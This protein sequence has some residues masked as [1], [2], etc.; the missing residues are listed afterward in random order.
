[1]FSRDGTTVLTASTDDTVRLWRASTAQTSGTPLVAHEATVWG[2]AFS[3]DGKTVLTGSGDNTARF[4]DAATGKLTMAPIAH[5][6]GVCGVAFSP[7]GKTILTG[8][9]DGMARLWDASSGRPI[10]SPLR[11]HGWVHAVAFSPDGKVL[12]T[13]S[14]DRMAMLW[15]AATGTPIGR[16]MQHED[17]IWS[18]AF[19]PDGKSVLTGSWDATARI[20]DAATGTPIGTPIEPSGGFVW[21]VAFSPDGKTILT[22]G[23]DG[24][25]RIWDAATRESVGDPMGHGTSVTAVAF[26][27]DGKTV[28]TGSYD[29]TVRLWDVA[30]RR[31]IGRPMPH[32]GL[33][34]AVAFSP[35]GKTILTGSADHLARLWPVAELPDDLGRVATWVE[36]ITAL[37][38]DD[39]G[40]IKPLDRTAWL[41]RHERLR[42]NG[43]APVTIKPYRLDPILFGPD[44]TAR[45]RAWVKRGRWKMAE[46]AFSAAV[47]ARPLDA[48]ILL[49]RA[50]YY[51]G[52]SQS[53]KA[54]LDVARV[55]DQTP[56]S[57]AWWSPLSRFLMSWAE[58]P[59]TFAELMELRPGDARLWTARARRHALCDEWQQALAAFSHGIDS[60]PP[61]SEEWFEYAALRLIAGDRTGYE[62]FLRQA[63]NRAGDTSDPFV[64][65]IL[66]R[67]CSLT[68]RP[69]VDPG[70]VTRWAES[71]VTRDRG[72]A[73]FF[74]LGMAHYRAGRFDEAVRWFTEPGI[75]AWGREGTMQV[76]LGLAMAHQ[77][78]GNAAKARHL[79]GEVERSWTAIDQ[80]RTRGAVN[81]NVIDWLALQPLRA[82]AKALIVGDPKDNQPGTPPVRGSE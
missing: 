78:R 41:E 27:P 61:D 6:E 5:P 8:S 47:D 39:S 2:V 50:Q 58:S 69:G 74:V 9:Y 34:R 51:S 23:G 55:L 22:G 38:L 67:T 76:E 31:P 44:P 77:R 7:D 42:Q 32:H 17:E 70:Q 19:S 45:A 75:E 73:A 79:L 13:G 57:R 26:S 81:M 37:T 15:D 18:V 62:D 21:G 52:R 54:N 48:A 65:Y 14:S 56:G 40:Q 3:P 28:V 80:A 1:M 29:R 20:W 43:G 24:K 16:P 46:A 25:A 35:D 10:G 12:L 30:T 60:A 71:A 59:Q 68:A 66:A 4:W 11:H 33:V 63:R 36:A 82:E 64:A 49:E 53:E 72:G